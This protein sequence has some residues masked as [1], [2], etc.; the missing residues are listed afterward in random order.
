[1]VGAVWEEDE[2]AINNKRL[3]ASA[4]PFDGERHRALVRNWRVATEKPAGQGKVDELNRSALADDAGAFDGLCEALK[5]PRV[6][7]E[8][9][10]A[11]HSEV[12]AALEDTAERLGER[13][14]LIAH[15]WEAAGH[16]REAARWRLR[17]GF[18]VANLVPRRR[19]DRRSDGRG[20]GA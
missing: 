17:A 10:A 8:R 16:P 18:R 1:M 15:H 12:A 4:W 14:D 13:A 7:G 19:W 5:D 11:L 2:H 20:P 9:R 6:F 3:P